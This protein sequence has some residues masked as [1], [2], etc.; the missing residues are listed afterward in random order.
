MLD[1]ISHSLQPSW[2]PVNFIWAQFYSVVH[3]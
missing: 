3:N 2:G 1:N